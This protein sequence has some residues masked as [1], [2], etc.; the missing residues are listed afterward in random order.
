MMCKWLTKQEKL[1]YKKV[2]WKLRHSDRSPA[3]YTPS[4]ANDGLTCHRI[5]G[6]DVIFSV[7]INSAYS[8]DSCAAKPHAH[9]KESSVGNFCERL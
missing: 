9:V 3:H 1:A 7:S 8:G 6:V 4:I 2:S 5:P